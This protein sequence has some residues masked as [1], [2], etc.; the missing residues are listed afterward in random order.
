MMANAM[1]LQMFQS[2]V[3]QHHNQQAAQQS[4]AAQHAAEVA[5]AA[6]LCRSAAGQQP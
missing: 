5:A 6:R 2:Y 4:V 1:A 3:T